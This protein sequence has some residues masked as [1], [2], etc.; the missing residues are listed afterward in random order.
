LTL[1]LVGIV[2][3]GDYE[4]A[5]SRLFVIMLV[6]VVG[7]LCLGV[8]VRSIAPS[9][10]DAIV[11]PTELLAVAL[12]VLAGVPIIYSTGGVILQLVGNGVVIILLLFTAVGI[13]VGH[14]LGGPVEDDRTVLALATGTR[15]PGFAVAVATVNF[16]DEKATLAV[17]LW[18]LIFAVIVSIP[19]VQWRKRVHRELVGGDF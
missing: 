8:V 9:V 11:R 13:A 1:T 15:H 12:L 10:A 6:S 17:I 3:G 4:I 7:P 18:H 14:F 16:P 2:F 19:Y 5:S